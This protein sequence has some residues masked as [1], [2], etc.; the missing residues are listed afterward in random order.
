MDKIG[1]PC[2]I[3]N[4]TD[5][6]AIKIL[7]TFQRSPAKSKMRRE[8]FSMFEK[9][10]AYRTTKTENPGVTLKLVKKVFRKLAR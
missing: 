4:M 2:Y 7:K 3:A 1:F 5:R 8:Y 6:Q 10:M 9:R